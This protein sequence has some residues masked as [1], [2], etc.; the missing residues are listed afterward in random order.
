MSSPL[1][2]RR[3]PREPVRACVIYAWKLHVY[4]R[5]C[6]CARCVRVC[7]RRRATRALRGRVRPGVLPP[8]ARAESLVV[9]TSEA[10]A[11]AA[12][13]GSRLRFCVRFV[14]RRTSVARALGSDPRESAPAWWGA[15]SVASSVLSAMC[16]DARDHSVSC[17]RAFVV[18][19]RTLYHP[20]P[21]TLRDNISDRIII[22]LT[23]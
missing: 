9:V 4:E 10:A 3:R 16:R 13:E 18:V 15:R 8:E 12:A 20:R 23:R 21:S 2:R 19:A 22:L 17:L 11:R 7:A 1:W 6:E 5:W 14:M